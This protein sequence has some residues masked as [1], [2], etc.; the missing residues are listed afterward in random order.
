MEFIL[1]QNSLLYILHRNVKS[2][3]F[4][5]RLRS[6]ENTAHIELKQ[7]ILTTLAALLSQYQTVMLARWNFHMQR[8]TNRNRY[9]DPNLQQQYQK[10]K[11]ILLLCF[12]GVVELNISI[13]TNSDQHNLGKH[14]QTNIDFVVQFRFNNISFPLLWFSFALIF[15]L[16]C[17][18]LPT[19]ISV[20]LPLSFPSV[21]IQT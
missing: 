15:Y 14:K 12:Y 13:K 9:I 20:S 17:S 21:S 10:N 6:S 2:K 16:A 7:C 4:Q 19:S 18:H 11:R 1:H 8:H 3:I 5:W